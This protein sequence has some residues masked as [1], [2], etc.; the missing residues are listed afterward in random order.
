MRPGP[1]ALPDAG[2]LNAAA[3]AALLATALAAAYLLVAPQSADLAAQVYRAG[4]FHRAG[5]LL[6]DTAWYGGPPLLGYSVLFPPL[7]ALLGVRLAGALSVVAAAALFGALVRAPFPA[8]RAAI[9][10]TWF[11]AGIAAQLLTGRMT[12]L[13]GVAIGLGAVLAAR[14]GRRALA[15]ALAAA[16]MLA[17]PVAGAFVALAGLGWAVAERSKFGAA[18][19]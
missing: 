3:G 6:W 7:G 11:A 8:R 9:G 1:F 2:R 13:F 18:L 4:L 14:H 19:A 12:F 10:A 16:T 17:S 15:V 5:W